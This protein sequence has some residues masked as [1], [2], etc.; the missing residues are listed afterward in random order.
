MLHVKADRAVLLLDPAGE[1]IGSVHIQYLAEALVGFGEEGSLE[2]GGLI[3][4]GDKLHGVAIFSNYLFA[5]YGPCC[6][7]YSS[8]HVSGELSGQS[9]FASACSN[10]STVKP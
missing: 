5:G 3:L 6:K 1:E 9:N 7:G 4:E 10:L 2:D 8:S